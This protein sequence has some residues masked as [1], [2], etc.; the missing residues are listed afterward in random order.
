M[1]NVSY[2]VCAYSILPHFAENIFV[3]V[4]DS[5]LFLV[6]GESRHLYS[7]GRV[8]VNDNP[9]ATRS[10][11]VLCY[12]AHNLAQLRVMFP[13]NVF[14]KDFLIHGKFSP[15]ANPKD[16]TM[17]QLREAAVA[18]MGPDTVVND[19]NRRSIVDTVT[20]EYTRTSQPSLRARQQL[21]SPLQTIP[22]AID[23]FT[24]S[25]KFNTP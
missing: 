17:V 19:G 22:V 18:I 13:E 23:Y 7:E 24:G 1:N 20:V 2:F 11:V 4:L 6:G 3:P 8:F 10:G 12:E 14:P 25:E 21:D 9:R 15:G 5:A 16:M